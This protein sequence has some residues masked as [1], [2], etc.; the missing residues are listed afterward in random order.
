MS[1][2]G[3]A[4]RGLIAAGLMFPLIALAESRTDAAPAAKPAAGSVQR[5][6]APRTRDEVSAEV[7]RAMHDGNWRCLTNNRGWCDRPM[8]AG[9]YVLAGTAA[10]DGSNPAPPWRPSLQ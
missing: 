2:P 10:S 9:P 7:V 8:R 3:S 6:D 4:A 5:A 1:I